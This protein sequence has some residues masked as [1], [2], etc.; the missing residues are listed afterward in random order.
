L[1]AKAI[2]NSPLVKTAV[3][4]NDPNVGRILA[5]VGDAFGNAGLP[6]PSKTLKLNIAGVTVFENGAFR[7]DPEAEGRLS[8][9][10]SAA[11][12]P[13]KKDGFPRHEQNVV[14]SLDLGQGRAAATVWGSDLSY[15]YIRENADYRS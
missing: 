12:Q 2:V 4:G 13:E 14:L 7:L 11:A 3:F 8:K 5:S 15:E 9:A 10:F 6:L 1:A